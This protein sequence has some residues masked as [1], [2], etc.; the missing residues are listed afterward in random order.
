M[1]FFDDAFQTLAIQRSGQFSLLVLVGRYKRLGP[2]SSQS[3]FQVIIS[4]SGS[5]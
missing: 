2:T 1:V 3:D 4:L 5:T